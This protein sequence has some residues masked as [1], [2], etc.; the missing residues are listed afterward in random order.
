M[1]VD[2]DIAICGAGPVGLTLAASL[3]K[4][5][6]QAN[7][8][9]VIDAKTVEQSARDPRSI[10]LSYGSRQLLESVGAW[11]SRPRLFTTFMYRVAAISAAR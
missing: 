9:A 10:A 4:H 5:G 2:F 11:P 3:V 6:A 1:H 7:R 8:I